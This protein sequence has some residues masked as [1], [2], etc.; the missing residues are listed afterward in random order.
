M[1]TSN[2][3]TRTKCPGCHRFVWVPTHMLNQWRCPGC[4]TTSGSTGQ[5]RPGKVYVRG[6]VRRNR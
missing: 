3:R 5:R 2:D 6:D 1:A 4:N